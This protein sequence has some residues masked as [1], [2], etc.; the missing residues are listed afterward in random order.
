MRIGRFEYLKHLIVNK[1][2]AFVFPNHFVATIKQWTWK[3]TLAQ[4]NAGKLPA[5]MDTMLAAMNHKK[6]PLV[7]YNLFIGFSPKRALIH[8]RASSNKACAS[9]PRSIGPYR[10]PMWMRGRE[11]RRAACFK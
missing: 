9:V 7:P 3:K 11:K 2:Q 4:F 5:A 10:T 1:L 8:A 6:I